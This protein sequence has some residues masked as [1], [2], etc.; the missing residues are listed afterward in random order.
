MK[1]VKLSS[2]PVENHANERTADTCFLIPGYSVRQR[3]IKSY[4]DKK[5]G[6]IKNRNRAPAFREGKIC[7]G[8]CA[9]MSIYVYTHV[10]VYM[11]TSLYIY[12]CVYIHIYVYMCVCVPNT[13]GS[14]ESY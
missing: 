4:R 5:F 3:N 8:L 6:D 13:A 10:Y 7:M 2:F 11:H 14:L 1:A 12:T 9:C